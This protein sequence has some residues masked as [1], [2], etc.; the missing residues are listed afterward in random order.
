MCNKT[1]F[2]LHVYP[3]QPYTIYG[4]QYFALSQS[5][6]T[7]WSILRIGNEYISFRKCSMDA[8]DQ[9]VFREVS[10]TSLGPSTEETFGFSFLTVKTFFVEKGFFV[11]HSSNT[12]ID[13]LEYISRK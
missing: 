2:R 3:P 8:L 12:C 7:N 1:A 9:V 13:R 6:M 11:L 4:Q 5:T 10:Y